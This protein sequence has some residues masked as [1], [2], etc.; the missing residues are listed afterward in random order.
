MPLAPLSDKKDHNQAHLQQGLS[1]T[2]HTPLSDQEKPVY[3]EASEE[4]IWA[5]NLLSDGA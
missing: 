2:S 4:T 1:E 3:M 5:R